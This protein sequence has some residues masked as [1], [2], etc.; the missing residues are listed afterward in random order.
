M[1]SFTT[2][3]VRVAAPL[4]IRLDSCQVGYSLSSLSR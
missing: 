1:L 3:I 4:P 2:A